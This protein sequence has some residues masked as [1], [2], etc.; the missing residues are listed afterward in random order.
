MIKRLK[1]VIIPILL[2]IICGG[3]CGKLVYEIYEPK[4]ENAMSARKIYLIQAGAYS[5]YDN[6]ISN[7]LVNNYIYYEDNDGLY[8]TVIG[9]TENYDNIEKITSTY[10]GEVIISE[11]YSEDRE[12][13]KKIEEYDKKINDLTNKEEIKNIV[14]KMLT[15]YKDKEDST[16]TKAS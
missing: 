4:A 11:Y 5:N 10:S 12:L 15:L 3:I 8:K 16:L 9:I 13:N 6:M 7:T 1:K 2:S 14:M